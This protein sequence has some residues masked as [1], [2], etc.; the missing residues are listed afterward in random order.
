MLPPS[1][2]TPCRRLASFGNHLDDDVGGALAIGSF[3]DDSDAIVHEL[4]ELLGPD[5]RVL[6]TGQ[7]R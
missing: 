1:S 2:S 7:E 6:G 5:R 3:G 4:S